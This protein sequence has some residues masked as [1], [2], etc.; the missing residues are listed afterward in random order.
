MTSSDFSE[1]VGTLQN[2]DRTRYSHPIPPLSS[3]LFYITPPHLPSDTRPCRH[4]VSVHPTPVTPNL[5]RDSFRLPHRGSRGRQRVRTGRGEKNRPPP[6]THP[7]SLRLTLHTHSHYTHTTHTPTYTPPG[8][9]THKHFPT[10]TTHIDTHTTH[11]HLPVHTTHTHTRVYTRPS[12]PG[13]E[14]SGTGPRRLGTLGP[15]RRLL[16]SLCHSCNLPTVLPSLSSYLLFPSQSCRSKTTGFV[17][18]Q[19]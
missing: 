14:T 1:L 15:S 8:P 19:S 5:S 3:P 7:P 9:H 13:H 17:Q 12:V 11:T 16:R 10:R 4:R 18:P 6:H 2:Q